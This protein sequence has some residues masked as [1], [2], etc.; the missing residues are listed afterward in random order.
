[1]TRLRQG[2]TPRQ[3]RPGK[4]QPAGR[5]RALRVEVSWL[6]GSLGFAMLTVDDLMPPLL[7][8]DGDVFMGAHVLGVKVDPGA[9]PFYLQV[10]PYRVDPGLLEGA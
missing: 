9:P 5:V 8:I 4:Q 10:K 1:M 2:A 6:D 7:M 3:A